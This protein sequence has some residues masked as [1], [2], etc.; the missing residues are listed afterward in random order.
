MTH[1]HAHEEAEHAGHHAHHPF[2]KRVAMTMIVVAA[3]LA[4]VKVIGHRAHNATLVYQIEANVHHTQESDQW[5]YFQAKKNRQYLYESQA[6]LLTLLPS[7]DG[8]AVALEGWEVAFEA[9]AEKAPKEKAP[10]K[11]KGKLTKKE[12]DQLRTKLIKQGMSKEEANQFVAL[13]GQG[14]NEEAAKQVLA[15]VKALKE[16]GI[17]QKTAVRVAS[18]QVKAREYRKDADEIETKARKL[19][20]K[21][22]ELQHKSEHKHHQAFY[23]DIGE[24]F[25]ELALVLS[26]VAILTKRPKFWYLGMALGLGG[27]VVVGLG[28]FVH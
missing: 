3:L 5:S 25:V 22:K 28:F 18:W 14:F 6:D 13:L 17:P 23:F 1:G 9:P 8:V 12:A 21:A 7:R 15:R 2:D 16:E 26:S 11:K 4:T 19:Q 10:E 24:L 20:E 27:L